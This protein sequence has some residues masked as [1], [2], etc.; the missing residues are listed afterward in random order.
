MTI[1]LRG[2]RP[3]NTLEV[4]ISNVNPM[5]LMD[6]VGH[7][8]KLKSAYEEIEEQG[9]DIIVSCRT[10]TEILFIANKWLDYKQENV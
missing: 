1:I 9:D 10:D 2:K 6:F 3:E 8:S 5:I 4:K 7:L